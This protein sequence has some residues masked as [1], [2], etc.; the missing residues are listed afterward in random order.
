M[1]FSCH[2]PSPALPLLQ[3]CSQKSVIAKQINDNVYFLSSIKMCGVIIIFGGVRLCE[4]H[5]HV[6]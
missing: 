2:L 4:K 3:Y 1:D 5:V 6:D